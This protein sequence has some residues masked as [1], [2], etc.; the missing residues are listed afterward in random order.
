M[1]GMLIVKKLK[2]KSPDGVTIH[3]KQ[4]IYNKGTVYGSAIFGIG[5]GITGACPGPIY[6][7]IGSG[8]LI[9]IFLLLSALAGTYAYS[10]FKER[11]PH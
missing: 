9:S 3:P 10:F 2:L 6:I 11:L 4:K 7:Q 8:Y 1:A 5:W